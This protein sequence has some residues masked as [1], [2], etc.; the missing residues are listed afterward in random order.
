MGKILSFRRPEESC[1]NCVYFVPKHNKV[2]MIDGN[3]GQ[4]CV[5]PDRIQNRYLTEDLIAELNLYR[6]P[7]KWCPKYEK[8]WSWKAYDLHHALVAACLLGCE[9]YFSEARSTIPSLTVDEHFLFVFIA[10]SYELDETHDIYRN[11][12]ANYVLNPKIFTSAKLQN[13]QPLLSFAESFPDTTSKTRLSDWSLLK[14]SEPD[15]VDSTNVTLAHFLRGLLIFVRWHNTC[16]ELPEEVSDTLASLDPIDREFTPS[17]RAILCA[18]NATHVGG[19]NGGDFE[20]YLLRNAIKDINFNRV[21]QAIDGLNLLLRLQGYGKSYGQRRLNPKVLLIR[22]IAS[23]LAEDNKEAL[24]F[25]GLL[26]QSWK[27]VPEI[28]Q[29]RK[30]LV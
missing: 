18:V 10:Y 12:L 27:S 30:L 2:P 23:V 1:A 14:E 29:F 22:S 6:D 5:H 28:V 11:N 15:L 9:R 7:N 19:F 26:P 17:E 13:F 25:Y 24:E 20:R 16:R 3:P 21:P 4:Y 8:A